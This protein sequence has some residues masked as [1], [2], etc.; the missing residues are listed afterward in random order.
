MKYEIYFK[1]YTIPPH[2]ECPA[3]FMEERNQYSLERAEELCRQFTATAVVDGY[4]RQG[5]TCYEPRINPLP[6]PVEPAPLCAHKRTK[7][8]I[9]FT[10]GTCQDCGAE[11]MVTKGCEDEGCPQHGTP[12]DHVVKADVFTQ[13]SYAQ[14]IKRARIRDDQSLAMKLRNLPIPEGD[15]EAWA[16]VE[17]ALRRIAELEAENKMTFTQF[18]EQCVRNTELIEEKAVLQSKLDQCVAWLRRNASAERDDSKRA[19]LVEAHNTV[20]A[21]KEGRA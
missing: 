21:I 8:N 6:L 15:A 20:L 2:N 1:G 12:H 9:L 11:L 5:D 14:S 17:E 10:H 3:A 19:G 13:A 7:W 4:A 16:R 18:G